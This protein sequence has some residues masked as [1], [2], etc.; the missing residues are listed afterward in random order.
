MLEYT[1]VSRMAKNE[2]AN[3]GVHEQIR[4]KKSNIIPI[5]TL[6]VFNLRFTC[7]FQELSK[8]CI[9]KLFT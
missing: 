1:R 7:P 3:F 4:K 6:F 2:I 5:Y 9:V 8:V